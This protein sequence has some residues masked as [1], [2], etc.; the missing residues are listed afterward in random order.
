MSSR[1]LLV[2]D[3]SNLAFLLAERLNREGYQVETCVDG[4]EREMKE[5][6]S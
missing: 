5:V 1:I 6:A 4:A 2:E 3:E